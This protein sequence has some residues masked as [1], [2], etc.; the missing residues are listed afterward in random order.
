MI[1]N[2]QPVIE[3]DDTAKFITIDGVLHSVIY[4]H[5]FDDFG[6]TQDTFRVMNYAGDIKEVYSFDECE[7]FTLEAGDH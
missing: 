5:S 4:H 6:A 7:T 3:L 1:S 2:K